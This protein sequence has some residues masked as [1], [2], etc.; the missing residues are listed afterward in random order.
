MVTHVGSKII[1]TPTLGLRGLVLWLKFDEGSGTTTKDSS[2]CN[3]H[4]VINGAT[5]TTG[6]FG[7]CL[8]FSGDYVEVA[9]SSSLDISIGTFAMFVY[10]TSS[11]LYGM[12]VLSKDE[13]FALSLRK[14][15]GA[16]QQYLDLFLYVGGSW[17]SGGS[18]MGVETYNWH[19]I[20][21]T[22]DGSQ[23]KLYIDG[24]L[25]DTEDVSGYIDKSTANL[26]VGNNNASELTKLTSFSGHIDEVRIYN[27]VLSDE[28]IKLLYCNRIG[29]VLSKSVS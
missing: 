4:G 26:W 29:A 10:P 24:E 2:L 20:A 12:A 28:E 25:K 17:V 11:H 9:D 7:Y 21:A 5:W 22:F 14:P 19:L 6:K 16:T 23:A 1:G 8:D 18:A 3:N 15:S 13:A 27:R